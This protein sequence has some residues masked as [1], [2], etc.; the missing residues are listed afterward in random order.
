M[1]KVWRGGRKA[2]SAKDV[3]KSKGTKT[4]MDKGLYVT[5]SR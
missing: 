2:F 4:R 5:G 1:T 3:N